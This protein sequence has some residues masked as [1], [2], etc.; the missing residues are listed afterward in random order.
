MKYGDAAT[1]YAEKHGIVRYA[2]VGNTMMYKESFLMEKA[3]YSVHV[4][5][6][7]MQETRTPIASD[8]GMSIQA[9]NHPMAQAAMTSGY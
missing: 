5:L 1:Q 4:N 6:D 7:T 3:T 9:M 2:V 8:R